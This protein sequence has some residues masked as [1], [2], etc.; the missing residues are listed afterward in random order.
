[1][2]ILLIALEL[3]KG[4]LQTRQKQQDIICMQLFFSK[5]VVP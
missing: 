2:A 5:E 4:T 3:S 1:M